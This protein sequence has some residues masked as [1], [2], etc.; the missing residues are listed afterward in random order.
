MR[1]S[2]PSRRTGSGAA[3]P[4]Q[5]GP[6]DLRLLPPALATW[7]ATAYAL[8]SSDRGA[9]VVAALC[10]AAA[11]LL[12]LPGRRSRSRAI[13][14]GCQG[15]AAGGG[16]PSPGARTSPTGAGRVR[17][18]AGGLR[19]AAALTLLCAAAGAGVGG[20]RSADLHRGPL[21][22]LAAAGGGRVTAEVTVTGDPHPTRPHVRGDHRQPGFVLVPAET[23]T[24][25]TVRVGTPVLLTVRTG[26][27][28]RAAW[29][30]LLP[31][32]RLRVSGQVGHP[33]SG[34]HDIAAVLYVKGTQPPDVRGAPNPVQHLA[35]RL[36]AG[37]RTATDKLAA[38]PRALLPGLVVGDTSLVPTDLE[39]AFRATDMLHLLAVSGG[40]LTVL[41]A[42]L[43]GPPGTAT[44]VERSGL[45]PR[46]GLSL[47][48]T[49]L[50]AGLLTI[51]F[52][53]VCRPQPSV[54]RA[55]ACGAIAILAIATGRRRSLLPALA[56]AVTALLLWDP[57]LARD[58]GFVLSVLATGSLLVLAPP[59]SAAL[60][61]RG[62]PGR[63]AE[64][65]AAASAAQ[66]AC[67][68]VI[69]VLDAHVS[70]VAVPCNLAAEFLVAPATVLGFAALAVAPAAIP[71]AH[72]LAWAASWP[73][74]VIARI[75]RTGAGLPGAQVAWA[76]DWQGALLL[77]ALLA[78]LALLAG[79]LLRRPWLCALLA[80]VLL[81]VLLRPAP[82]TRRFTGW[83]PPD[84]RLVA[85]D[86]GQGDAL[87][88]AAG[89][90]RA[91]VVDAGPD[92]EL[93]DGCLRR[94][95]VSAVP[96][97]ILTHFHADHV[98]GIPG[99][100]HGRAVGAVETTGLEAPP[101]Q[102]ALVYRVAH[103]AGVPVLRVTPGERRHVGGLSWRVLWPDGRFA[104]P[105]PA[106]TEPNDASITLL[107]RTHGLKLLLPG[108]LEPLA[109]RE[110]LA[111][112]PSLPTVDV[113]KV[114]HHGSAYQ[115]PEFL[116]RLHPRAALVSV[117]V[118]NPYGHPSR[119]TLRL[120]RSEG[121]TVLR[122]D[123]AG[124]LA[125]TGGPHTLA[126]HSRG[127]ST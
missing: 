107:V 77:A 112:D 116:D 99:V 71:A 96:L 108:D 121:A 75:A 73:T 2:T 37:L 63:L 42:L 82:L 51:G 3:D 125:V 50:L 64:A 43:I 35:G 92:P 104:G 40:N 12:A 38:D 22:R 13:A 67:A 8:G 122:T 56:G 9:T 101:G 14:P 115:D 18:A 95:D 109:Q 117:G 1:A 72:G 60:R 23:V 7:L 68:P 85:C 98:A 69:A 45:A 84:W 90:G 32:T 25:G 17:P 27:R 88:L 78:A 55:A 11:V 113:L 106:D 53:V 65:L 44:L 94:L 41:L 62:V 76:P 61:R 120:L 34:S 20:L 111:E 127:P 16:P 49:A 10:A 39:D 86:V 5:P 89:D 21:P 118:G 47:R 4:R 24:A 105:A 79:R 81:L 124:S 31:S 87:V 28:R 19:R 29:L 48:M 80:L 123:L 66:A 33:L 97:L 110:L 102:A 100:L 58:M 30:R 114:P 103:E 70:L 52:V 46:L 36:R 91:I 119:R 26:S 93:V 57:W 54:L 59:A 126:V 74:A 6:T 15:R 83:P